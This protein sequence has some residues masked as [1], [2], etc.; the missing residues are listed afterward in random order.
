MRW[1]VLDR[2]RDQQ[3]LIQEALGD[4]GHELP[5]LGLVPLSHPVFSFVISPKLHKHS[6]PFLVARLAVRDQYNQPMGM[7]I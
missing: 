4:L 6:G 3:E 2:E 1:P 5:I 7:G